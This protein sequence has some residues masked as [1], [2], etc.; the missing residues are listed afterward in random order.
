M[1]AGFMSWA[2]WARMLLAG[3]LTGNMSLW[4]VLLKGTPTIFFQTIMECVRTD[5]SQALSCPPRSG[6][7]FLETVRQAL[8]SSASDRDFGGTAGL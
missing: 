8:R 1:A 7:A 3:R 5:N 6:W 4:A 2:A